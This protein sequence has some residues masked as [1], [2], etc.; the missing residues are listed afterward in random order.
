VQVS[1]ELVRIVSGAPPTTKWAQPF[2]APLTDVFQVQADIASRVA[3][4]LDLALAPNVPQSLAAPTT[5]SAEAYDDYLRANQYYDRATIP[6]L[7]L[8][9][10]LY[11]Q[12]IGRDSSFA[13]A[14]A[15]LARSEALLYRLR[16]DRSAGQLQR[17]EQAARRALTLTPELPE[18][19]A[20]MGYY[21][22]WG[23]A[24]FARALEQFELASRGEPNNAELADVVGLVLRREGRWDEA[25]ASLERASALDPRSS[26]V[27]TDLGEEYLLMRRYTEAERALDRGAALSPDVPFAYDLL[28]RHYVNRDGSLERSRQVARQA[29]S[30]MAPGRLFGSGYREVGMLALYALIVSDSAFQTELASLTPA[31]MGNDTLGYFAF[32]ASL[33]RYRSERTLAR[34]YEDSARSTALRVSTRHEENAFTE[35]QLALA[36]AYLGR[37]KEA[38]EAGKR[39]VMLTPV[40]KDAVFGQEGPMALAEVYAVLGDADAAV[41]QL[42]PPLAVPSFVSAA[43]L[44]ID[45]VWSPLRG[46]A[47]FER[48]ARRS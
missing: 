40:S 2:D 5:T 17:V 47:E 29:L 15:R 21:Y 9:S 13:L 26:F 25:I 33:F 44:R 11:R 18:A 19:H 7:R 8:A 48:L 23:R 39:A 16:A 1:P 46:N 36:D 42:K 28:M 31:L 34:A 14:W 12:A 38:V 43:W 10:Q 37:P 30:R 35:A 22:F 6:D 20:A 45:P 3:S 4:A 32:E 41:S 27:L 24:D